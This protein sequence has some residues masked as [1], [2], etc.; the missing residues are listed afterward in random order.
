MGA[1]QNLEAVEELRQC[2]RDGDWAHVAD[3]LT[4]GTVMRIAGVPRGLGGVVEG[5][6][7][8]LATMR[9]NSDAG[10]T[11]EVRDMFGDDNHVCVVGKL[12][13]SDFPGN[14]FLRSSDEPFT[15]WQA[16][17]YRFDHG[18]IAETT[19]YCN[20]LDVYAQT[21]IIDVAQLTT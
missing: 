3:L 18:R 4:E 7:A 16:N 2:A 13:A 21:G 11:L 5:R 14:Q 15:T 17:I 1:K 12:T 10:G 8:V 20:W 19:M 9:A 6:D